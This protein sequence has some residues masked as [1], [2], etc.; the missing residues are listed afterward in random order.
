MNDKNKKFVLEKENPLTGIG[1][2]QNLLNAQEIRPAK[3]DT[4]GPRR[5]AV[6]GHR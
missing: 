1:E 5:A 3:A 6:S 2:C 4:A